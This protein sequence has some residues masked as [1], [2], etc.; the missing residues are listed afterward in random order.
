LWQAGLPVPPGFC[1]TWDGLENV[2]AADLNRALEKLGTCAFAVRSSA[3]CEDALDASF[4]GILLSRLNI[5]SGDVFPALQDIRNSASSA[6]ARDY[7]R[8]LNAST[9]QH[10]AAVVQTFLPAES[11]G[12]LFMRDGHYVVEAS[13]GLGP[14]VVEGLVRP[15]RWTISTDGSVITSQI[16][17]KD[18][19]VVAGKP[20]G[21]S[22]TPVDPPCRRRPCLTLESIHELSRLAGE[23]ARL[24]GDPQDIEWAVCDRVWLLQSRPLTR[25]L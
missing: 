24:F 4:A 13:W 10:V 15:D 17:D 11:S 12:V 9:S 16:S 1:I 3:I 25:S 2:N 20:V 23:C 7:S 5:P 22:Q 19:A 21:I 8:R 18:V 14:G 6:A